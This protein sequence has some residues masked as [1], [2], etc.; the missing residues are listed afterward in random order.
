[1]LAS[2]GREDQRD[3]EPVSMFC[4]L[5]RQN[6]FAHKEEIRE[7]EYMPA[8]ILNRSTDGF[9]SEFDGNIRRYPQFTGVCQPWSFDLQLCFLSGQGQDV[10]FVR[11]MRSPLT[12]GFIVNKSS[13]LAV[14]SRLSMSA[15]VTGGVGPELRW[16]E[17]AAVV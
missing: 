16:I 3:V 15:T 13:V 1:M 6:P 5:R 9:G 8:G 10:Y 4:P 2:K 11:L 12:L 14:D 7:K 17:V